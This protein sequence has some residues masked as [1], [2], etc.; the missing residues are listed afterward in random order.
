MLSD[1][2][3]ANMRSSL[4][5]FWTWLRRRQVLRHDQ[6][7]EI[8]LAVERLASCIAIRPGELLAIREKDIDL[9]RGYLF[10]PTPRRAG[11]SGCR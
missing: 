5:A 9:A 2:S 10:I 3:R 4:H 8:P 1:K 7:P 11:R 6:A